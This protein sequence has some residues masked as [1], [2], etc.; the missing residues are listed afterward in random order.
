MISATAITRRAKR[1]LRFSGLV[2]GEP[3]SVALVA[4]VRRA[5]WDDLAAR[6]VKVVVWADNYFIKRWTRQAQNNSRDC[7]VLAVLPC[8]AMGPPW[9]TPPFAMLEARVDAAVATVSAKFDTECKQWARD[10]SMDW[11]LQGHLRAP[12]LDILRYG[13]VREEVWKP[14]SMLITPPGD[15]AG[16]LALVGHYIALR[17]E[18]HGHMPM[19]L[20][21]NL[22][23]RYQKLLYSRP[24]DGLQAA[25]HHHLRG[26]QPLFGLWHVYKHCAQVVWRQFTPW[27][28]ALHP[29]LYPPREGDPPVLHQKL[30]LCLLE[31]MFCAA[32]HLTQADLRP[33]LVGCIEVEVE[34]EPILR[35]R[36]RGGPAGPTPR[37]A[38]YRY[39]EELLTVAIPL[40]LHLGIRVRNCAWSPHLPVD[41]HEVHTVL[42]IALFILLR[43][44]GHRFT[45]NAVYVRDTAVALLMLQCHPHLVH[46]SGWVEESCEAMLSRL[47]SRLKTNMPRTLGELTAIY[48]AVPV[49]SEEP[50]LHHAFPSKYSRVQQWLQEQCAVA[51]N[52]LGRCCEYTGGK[53]RYITIAD[54][55]TAVIP[56]V[57]ATDAVHMKGVLQDALHALREATPAAD[58]RAVGDALFGVPAA[59]APE[60]AAALPL[61][62]AAA[63]VVAAYEATEMDE[64]SE[65]SQGSASSLANSE[66]LGN[67]A[68]I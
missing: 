5:E 3:P 30:R 27:L 45:R 52:G 54:W 21:Q 41:D 60:D 8:P 53:A 43:Y 18:H 7:T 66:D 32:T 62:V 61:P 42:S 11:P 48:L 57:G 49:R 1:R 15:L 46:P 16:L 55:A 24:Y 13:R 4:A 36:A 9:A 28:A 23:W 22:W 14:Q 50:N 35:D 33:V 10:N 65:H 34:E 59:M 19:L 12:P 63:A 25:L 51:R 6:C 38:R 31:Q 47:A 39:L 40:V 64:D 56:V 29:I 58:S 44:P 2:H 17:D 68:D 67:A 37:Q 26:L 20:D